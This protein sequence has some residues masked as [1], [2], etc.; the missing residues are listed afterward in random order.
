[1]KKQLIRLTEE[2][3][4]QIIE[5]TV[6]RIIAE[7][8]E[9]EGLWDSLKSF[10]GQYKNRGEQKAKEMGKAAGES[11]KN[12]YN[13]TKDAAAQKYNA[14]KDAAN[15]KYNAVK[16]AASQKYNAAKQFGNT[17]KQDVQNTWQGAQRD[18]SMKDMQKAFNNFK[19]AVEKFVKNGGQL[20][21][22]MN[23][24]ISGIEKMLNSYQPNF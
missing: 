8:S 12:K 22:Q 18:G 16:D 11:I 24:R 19:M 2:D 23:S 7:N 14:V 6:H 20:N 17:V 15:Q 13:A 21:P 3:L 5:S 4:N 10:A 1:M 9:D